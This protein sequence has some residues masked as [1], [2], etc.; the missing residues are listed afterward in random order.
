MRRREIQAVAPCPHLNP[1]ELIGFRGTLLE[2]LQSF[3]YHLPYGDGVP[4]QPPHR[5]MT[6]TGFERNAYR[7]QGGDVTHKLLWLA[8]A[9]GVGTVARYA[10]AGLVQRFVEGSFPWGT[11]AVNGLG[12]LIFGLVW[13]VAS[14]RFAFSPEVRTILLVG[15][16]GAFTTFSTAIAEFGQLV[17]DAE[18]LRATIFLVGGNAVGVAAF[19]A[20]SAL[21]RWI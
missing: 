14:E 9:G 8:I 21:G 19:F 7:S 2:T 5:L 12:C 17:L 3:A 10:L 15:F 20:G 13:A 1:V 18:W 4:R 11:L 6:P 16:L